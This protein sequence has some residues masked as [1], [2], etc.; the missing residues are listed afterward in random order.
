MTTFFYGGIET[1]LIIIEQKSSMKTESDLILITVRSILAILIVL[2]LV[3]GKSLLIPFAWS[4][5]IALAGMNL[6][7]RVEKKTPASKKR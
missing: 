5:L 2:V 4:T 3:T 6:I 1:I 7:D